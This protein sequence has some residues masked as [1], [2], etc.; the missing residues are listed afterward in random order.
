MSTSL[1]H[2]RARGR[3]PAARHHGRPA[4]RRTLVGL[5]GAVLATAPVVTLPAAAEAAPQV[6]WSDRSVVAGTRTTAT[7]TP[8]SV[9]RSATPVL[10][11]RFPDAWRVADPTALSTPDGL[12]LRVPTRQYGEFV[13]R[14]AA[15][16]DNG[17]VV[18]SSS[19]ATVT[20]R[21]PYDPAGPASSHGFM[22]T[23]RWQWDSCRTLTWKLNPKASPKAARKQVTGAFKRLHAATGLEFSYQ[24]TTTQ[25]P[26]TGGVD[27]TDIVVGWMRRKAF[28]EK[29]GSA[30]GVGGASYWTGWRLPDGTPVSRAARGGVVLNAG[31]NDDLARGFGS[32]YTWGEVLMHELGHVVGLD[33]TSL[34]TQLMYPSI[35]NGTALWGAG[36]L[37]GL[38]T[39]G[40]TL[41]CLSPQPNRVQTLRRGISHH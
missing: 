16:D 19:T 2:L 34:D 13:Y 38:T 31:Y 12:E 28:S 22:T 10:Q 14:V 20:V 30:V 8:A 6:T 23:P 3:R 39:L 4:R 37:A 21:P 18:E 9:P 11:R 17:D 26:R 15:V 1:P 5:L 41:G 35:T 24:G 25:A 29:F 36:D 40:D 32:G 7:V 33:H 27:G